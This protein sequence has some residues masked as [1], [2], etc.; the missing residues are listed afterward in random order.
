MDDMT[1]DQTQT[2]LKI[3]MANYRN[4]YNSHSSQDITI[5]KNTWQFLLGGQDY[6]QVYNTVMQYIADGNEFPPTPGQILNRLVKRTVGKDEAYT[7]FD[8]IIYLIGR[9]GSWNYPK[10]LEEMSS[11]EKKIMT[12]AYYNQLCMSENLDVAR[13]QY[14]DYY[15]SLAERHQNDTKKLTGSEVKKL[16]LEE[17]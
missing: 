7:S 1:N 4:Q 3:L 14:R 6:E 11:I 2:L 10:A 15:L 17:L 12:K 8:H 16:T 9:Y 13:S 5:L